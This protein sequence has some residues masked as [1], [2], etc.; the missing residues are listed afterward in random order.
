MYDSYKL[1]WF[2]LLIFILSPRGNIL[3]IRWHN[4]RFPVVFLNFSLKKQSWM[5]TPI[6]GFANVQC[7]WLQG[8]GLPPD[9]QSLL[10][11]NVSLADI[12]TSK[13]QQQEWYSHLAS[14]GEASTAKRSVN[15][16]L[17]PK[18]RGLLPF[19]GSDQ[20]VGFHSHEQEISGVLRE[21]RWG[22]VFLT[23]LH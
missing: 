7:V 10:P 16:S 23:N 9:W 12:L 13:S 19:G 14:L 8:A 20:I 2:Q 18:S 22:R 4:L 5:F 11:P 3:K 6:S 1:Y 21:T 15:A 17:I